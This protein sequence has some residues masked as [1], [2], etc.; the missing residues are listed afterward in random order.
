M[1]ST[2]GGRREKQKGW[3]QACRGEGQSSHML[4]SSVQPKALLEKA[5]CPFRNLWDTFD[6]C[7]PSLQG[8]NFAILHL[9]FFLPGNCN[10]IPCHV[11][12][13][14]SQAMLMEMGRKTSQPFYHRGNCNPEQDEGRKMTIFVG[15]GSPRE[16]FFIS[17]ESVHSYMHSTHQ[18]QHLRGHRELWSSAALVLFCHSLFQ[19]TKSHFPVSGGLA[20]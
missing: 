10:L 12:P 17:N 1:G 13:P 20:Q 9:F 3:R 5:S 8:C 11:L 4:G 14:L 15:L 18:C 16:V 19:H 2:C 7:S 6:F